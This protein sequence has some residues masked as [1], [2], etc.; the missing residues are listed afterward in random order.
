MLPYFPSRI[1]LNNGIN[2]RPLPSAKATAP[3]TP[4]P[5]AML[6]RRTVSSQYARQ[7]GDGHG[8]H[9]RSTAIGQDNLNPS[10][11][12]STHGFHPV[13]IGRNMTIYPTRFSPPPSSWDTET[14]V[15]EPT[16]P[17]P[18]D[19]SELA[20]P[21]VSDINARGR[22]TALRVRLGQQLA[23]IV[24]GNG[25]WILQP[26]LR[27]QASTTRTNNNN[28]GSIAQQALLAILH[29]QPSANTTANRA[30]RS[31]EQRL[32]TEDERIA[33]VQQF[34]VEMGYSYTRQRM[35]QYEE[36]SFR[37]QHVLATRILAVFGFASEEEVRERRLRWEE[38]SGQE[39]CCSMRDFE[40]GVAYERCLM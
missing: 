7:R 39:G 35:L 17:D 29:R 4:T 16:T 33:R 23:P 8:S 22:I 20:P 40:N 5:A 14:L 21:L 11:L 37:E 34:L 32:A 28:S 3:T 27:P 31:S 12:S 9:D 18:R 6:A 24:Y 25:R 10:R 26:N 38:L 19:Y 13:P 30:K 36:L 15:D 1:D 2:A